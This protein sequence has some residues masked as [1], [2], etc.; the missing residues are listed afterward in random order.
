MKNYLVTAIRPISSGTLNY[1][2]PELYLEYKKMWEMSLASYEKFIQEPFEVVVWNDPVPDVDAHCTEN[3]YAIKELWHKE[4]CNIL[5]AGADTLMIQPTSIFNAR[6]PEFRM[7]NTTDPKEV[8]EFSTYLNDDVRWYP[9]TMSEN[10]WKIGE[11]LLKCKDNSDSKQW[12]FDQ[13]RHNAMF[14]SQDIPDTD[15]LHP[16][17]AY[18]AMNLRVLAQNAV[19]WHNE[20]NGID[21]NQAHI[22]HFHGSRGSQAVINIM[23]ELCNQLGIQT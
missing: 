21:I 14:W 6:F 8:P 18:Q 5:W 3:W 13:L 7:F 22:L 4:P 10:V 20:W 17:M 1:K 9:Y 15:R 11:N 12:G 2:D 23:K 16:E 19:D